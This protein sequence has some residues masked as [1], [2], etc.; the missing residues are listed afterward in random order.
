[1][2]FFFD[3]YYIILIIPALLISVWAQTKVN[4]AFNKYSKI[5]SSRGYTA[6]QIARYILD[7]NGLYNVQIDK[8]FSERVRL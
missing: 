8:L 7:N 2:P 3:Y 1:M 6:S 4:S 5:F